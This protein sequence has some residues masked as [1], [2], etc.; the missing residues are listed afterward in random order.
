VIF[1][2]AEGQ[3]VLRRSEMAVVR[4]GDRASPEASVADLAKQLSEQA[5][6]LARQ[7]IALAKAELAVKSKHAGIAAGMFGVAGALG[8][9]A[10]GAVVAAA[11]LGLA[12]A[13]SGCL[14][15]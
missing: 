6:R 9:Y 8:F 3:S 1:R 12:T 10:L 4:D 5:S 7:E 14:R 13:F 11:I 15:R 2:E